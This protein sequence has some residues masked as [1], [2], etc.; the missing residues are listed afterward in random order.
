MS[1]ARLFGLVA[2][3]SGVVFVIG[4]LVLNESCHGDFVCGSAAGGAWLA[5]VLS[6]A[7]GLLSLL[8]AGV[9]AIWRRR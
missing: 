4:V 1:G 9:A 6:A 5:I 7:V 2:L 3:G 8:L